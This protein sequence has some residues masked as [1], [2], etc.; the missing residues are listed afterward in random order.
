MKTTMTPR[1]TKTMKTTMTPRT[2]MNTQ[3]RGAR[4]T[5]NR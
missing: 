2:T 5:G 4:R 1:T 3:K